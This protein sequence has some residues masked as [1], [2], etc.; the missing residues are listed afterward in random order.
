[1][2][3]SSAYLRGRALKRGGVW[4][5]QCIIGAPVGIEQL[6]VHAEDRGMGGHACGME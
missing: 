1:M 2:R 5:V 4:S 6:P 3:L